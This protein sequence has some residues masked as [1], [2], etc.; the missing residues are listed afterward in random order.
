MAVSLLVRHGLTAQTGPVLT[1]W[2]PGVHLDERGR[3]Q[4]DA[5]GAR[6]ASLP[7]AR[8]VTSPLD[9]CQD[10][11][12]HLVDARDGSGPEPVVDERLGEVRYGDWT[13]RELKDLRKE[14]LWKVVAAQPSAVQFPGGDALVDVQARALAAVREHDAAVEAEHGPDALWV[15]VSHGDVLKSVVAHA[16][17]MHLDAF[18]RV[19]VDPC[20]LSVVRWTPERP[21]VLRVNDTGG[22]VEALR[23]PRRRRR[24]ATKDAAVGGGT[25]ARG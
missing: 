14:P 1:G 18:Q 20:S 2:T 11:A 21:Y 12:R 17:G 15:A 22:D 25:G 23:P 24:R 7:L 9:R 6:L 13:G 16:Y 19:L 8:V 4:A 5:L 10:T 3:G